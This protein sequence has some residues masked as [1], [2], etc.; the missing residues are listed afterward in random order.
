MVGDSAVNGLSSLYFIHRNFFMVWDMKLIKD[1]TS[2]GVILYWTGTKAKK[3]SPDFHNQIEAEE[4][5]KRYHLSQ[6]QGEERRVSIY[7]RRM[8][9][10]KRNFYDVRNRFV[11]SNPN[12]RRITDKPVKVDV[13]LAHLKLKLMS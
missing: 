5:Q 13:D 6:Y 3:L 4:W 11:R 9:E 12:G 10:V 2:D 7:D 8:D 1:L